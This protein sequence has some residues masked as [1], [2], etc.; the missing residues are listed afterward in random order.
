MLLNRIRE[1][2][3]QKISFQNLFCA[4]RTKQRCYKGLVCQVLKQCALCAKQKEMRRLR[5]LLMNFRKRN[6]SG[7]LVIPHICKTRFLSLN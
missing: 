2:H 7:M 1:G 3:Y 4:F 6:V 5:I